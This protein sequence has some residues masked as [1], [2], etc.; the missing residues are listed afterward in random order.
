M[1]WVKVSSAP[2]KKEFV[3]QQQHKTRDAAQQNIFEYIE[4]FYNP[5]RLHSSLGYMS[6]DQFE[7]VAYD[8]EIYTQFLRADHIPRVYSP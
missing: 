8:S 6:P 5:H 3:Y 1:L 7:R 4:A 2:Q